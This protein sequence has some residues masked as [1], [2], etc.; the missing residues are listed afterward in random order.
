MEGPITLLS[1]NFLL[2]R[3][4][5]A[6]VSFGNDKEKFLKNPSVRLGAV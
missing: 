3:M 2:R 4:L 1:F 6:V 5:L